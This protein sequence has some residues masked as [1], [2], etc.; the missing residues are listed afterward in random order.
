VKELR[1][2]ADATKIGFILTPMYLDAVAVAAEYA[3]LIKIRFADHENEE[4]IEKALETRKELIISVPCR[5]A[6]AYNPQIN[7]CFCAPK[8]PPE[9]EDFNLELSI[10]CEGFSSHFPHTVFDL[11]YAINRTYQNAYIEKHVMPMP[12][13]KDKVWINEPVD[14]KVS[15]RF[16][17]LKNFINQLELIEKMGRIRI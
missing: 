17:A 7:Y 14:K 13:F 1:Q 2:V 4:L 12:I 9:P 15:V 3:E 5:P 10:C 11:A 8:Y 16:D 6:N